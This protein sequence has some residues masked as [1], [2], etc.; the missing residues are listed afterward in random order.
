M[1]LT[2]QGKGERTQ[3]KKNMSFTSGHV[4]SIN[5]VGGLRVYVTW[6]QCQH[7]Q[8]RKRGSVQKYLRY[9]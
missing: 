4:W 2:G 3:K 5:P 9:I 6:C 7:V 8:R 1:W